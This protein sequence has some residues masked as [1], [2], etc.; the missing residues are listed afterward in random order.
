MD[1]PARA[2]DK[3]IS[4]KIGRH[5]AQCRLAKGMTQATL[6]KIVG[7]KKETISRLE[8]AFTAPSLGRLSMI[9]D[10]L[11]LAL[12]DLL[13]IGSV[14]PSDEV[15]ALVASLRDLS[16]QRRAL[17]LRT[18]TELAGLLRTENE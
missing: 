11:D 18:A 4:E 16:P 1:D 13:V 2:I 3:K 17:V 5:I 9:C 8:T 10:A 12:G 15:K 6:A 14:Q 7:V